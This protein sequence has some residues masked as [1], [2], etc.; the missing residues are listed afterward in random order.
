MISES[1][2]QMVADAK[3]EQAIKEGEIE[4]IQGLGQP[5]KFD[6]RVN[7]PNWWLNQKMKSEEI[8]KLKSGEK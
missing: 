1:A 8:K 4:R 6:W 5:F 7:D 3:I 2:I